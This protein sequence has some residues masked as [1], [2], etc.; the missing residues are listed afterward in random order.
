MRLCL[1]IFGD[2]ER[3]HWQVQYQNMVENEQYRLDS[4]ENEYR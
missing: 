2:G 3:D 1:E 4:I